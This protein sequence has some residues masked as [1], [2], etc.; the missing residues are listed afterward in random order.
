MTHDLNNK[1]QK[2]KIAAIFGLYLSV[3]ISD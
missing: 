1:F 3:I 2:L